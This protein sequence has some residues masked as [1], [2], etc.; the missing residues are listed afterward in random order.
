MIKY[1]KFKSMDDFNT[2]LSEMNAG[3][4]YPDGHG[5]ET[6]SYPTIGSDGLI[7]A[8]IRTED[9]GY[10]DMIDDPP[11]IV[12]DYPHIETDETL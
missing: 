12:D 10:L 3:K 6:Y 2:R 8:P 11:V 4:N 5:T 1:A 9:L 7:Y